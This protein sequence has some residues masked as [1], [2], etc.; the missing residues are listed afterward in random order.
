MKLHGDEL[1]VR[2]ARSALRRI[3]PKLRALP[4]SEGFV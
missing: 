2:R 1:Q 3:Q 4:S